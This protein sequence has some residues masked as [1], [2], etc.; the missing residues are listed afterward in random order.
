MVRGDE[1]CVFWLSG[2]AGTGKS[3]IARTIAREHLAPNQLG[4]SFFFTRGGGDVG[5][6]RKFFTTIA[7]QLIRRSTALKRCILK[8]VDENRDIAKRALTD[9]WK[10]LILEPLTIANGESPQL[11]LLLVI[12]ALDECEGDPDVRLILQLLATANK[13]IPTIQ[14]RVL[15]TSRPETPIR[16]GFR[17]NSGIWHRDLVL[18]AVP[19]E[20]VDRDITIYFLEE[21]KDI[22]SPQDDPTITRLV[23]KAC[24]LFIWAAT[25]CRFI[26]NGQNYEIFAPDRLSLILEGTVGEDNPE[27]G[28]DHIYTKIL[29]RSVGGGHKHAEKKVLFELF[30]RVI[31]SIVILFDP[32]SVTSL[33]SLLVF[34]NPRVDRTRI[35][36]LLTHLHSVLEVPE[37]SADPVRLLHPS[38]RDFLLADERCYE[39][40]LRV[41]EKHAH[42]TLADGCIGVMS[43]SLRRDICGLRLPGSLLSDVTRSQVEQCIRPE[44]QYA[45]LY[46]IQHIQK[47][48]IA[49][50]DEEQVHQFL[51]KHL[52]HWLEALA[53]LER[54]SEAIMALISLEGQIEVSVVPVLFFGFQQMITNN[55][56]GRQES[57][58]TRIRPGCKACCFV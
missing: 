57:W 8:A 58:S 40:Q 48:G 43:S 50:R 32:L 52:L 34:S 22:I 2:M 6:A 14:L 11:S 17:E 7:F 19:R 56:E 5:N 18:N 29:S 35:V 45:C 37:S 30:R 1:R 46:W 41:N 20:V 21:L 38:F 49:L 15:V 27:E 12:D 13:H 31:G 55:H 44:L 4:A 10:L 54:T 26:K 16:L 9:Q 42:R 36:R 25:V 23:E 53:W 39:P 33:G 24:G 3:T 51:R 28:L 47:S